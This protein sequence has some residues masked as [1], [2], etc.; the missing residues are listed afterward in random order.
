MLFEKYHEL[1]YSQLAEALEYL[2]NEMKFEGN[3]TC[4]INEKIVIDENISIVITSYSNFNDWHLDYEKGFISCQFKTETYISDIKV[5]DYRFYTNKEVYDEWRLGHKNIYHKL[6]NDVINF[7]NDWSYTV[8]IP[9]RIG[10]E[11]TTYIKKKREDQTE[12]K[13]KSIYK[14]YRKRG[15]KLCQ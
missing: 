11:I 3:K 6:S 7:I 9:K 2:S 10:S 8:L 12:K 5:N 13:L 1:N 14:Q 4:E 15:R